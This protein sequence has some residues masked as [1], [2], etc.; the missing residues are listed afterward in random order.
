MNTP[1]IL[2]SKLTQNYLKFLHQ[3]DK[4]SGFETIKLKKIKVEQSL[5]ILKASKE[6]FRLSKTEF[7]RISEERKSML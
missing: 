7:E 5:E 2:K 3:F 1:Q 6:D 4:F